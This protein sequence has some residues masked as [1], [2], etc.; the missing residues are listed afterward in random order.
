MEESVIIY[1]RLHFSFNFFALLDKVLY[2]VL[3]KAMGIDKTLVILGSVGAIAAGV[4]AFQEG[5][6][7][8]EREGLCWSS[9]EEALGGITTLEQRASDPEL[10]RSFFCGSEGF[11][12]R[13]SAV[14]D[15]IRAIDELR[16]EG[17]DT[18]NLKDRIALS[19]KKGG[20]VKAKICSQ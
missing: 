7:E 16:C 20:A 2:F 3:N 8:D 19:E 12:S 1:E 4:T 14:R 6:R 13:V 15:N 5:Q 11:D 10:D 9:R 18:G 17:I